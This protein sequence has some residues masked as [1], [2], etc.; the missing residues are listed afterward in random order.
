MKATAQVLVIHR[1]NFTCAIYSAFV[2]IFI[3]FDAH[4]KIAKQFGFYLNGFSTFAERE[5]FGFTGLEI[6]TWRD[7]QLF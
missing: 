3:I 4:G 1:M 7:F 2:I 6:A 5:F